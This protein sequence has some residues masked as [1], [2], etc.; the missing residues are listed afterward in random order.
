MTIQIIC[1]LSG[2]I[3]DQYNA[4][5][6]ARSIA[7]LYPSETI[8]V[9]DVKASEVDKADAL[10]KAFSDDD[11][12][13]VVGAGDDG[14]DAALALKADFK[15]RVYVSWSGHQLPEGREISSIDR[16]N[17]PKGVASH[18]SKV[19]LGDRLTETTG[20]PHNLTKADLEAE[21]LKWADRIPTTDKKK[22]VVVLGGDAP[23]ADNATQKFY[24]VK[25]AEELADYVADLARSGDYYI[26]ATSGPRVGKFNHT[27][28]EEDKTVHRGDTPVSEPTDPVSEAFVNRLKSK[29][30][31]AGR[32][33][34]FADFRYGSP[35]ISAYR[36]LLGLL[37]ESDVLMLP[38]ESV[39]MFSE[40]LGVANNRIGY[41][42]GSMNDGHYKTFGQF[43]KESPI[44]VLSLPTATGKRELAASPLS[45]EV[46]VSEPAAMII[47]KAIQ[48][49]LA[50]AKTPGLQR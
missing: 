31:E 24:T 22:L 39:S 50:V 45:G 29:G 42:T 33:F 32:D 13:I 6:V 8:F 27:T 4:Q 1:L 43:S 41:I 9:T 49:D 21:R 16:V 5:G 15:D 25:E 14:L 17:L 12:V 3:G 35:S 20:V 18:A 37:G 34:Y 40:T 38:G 23:L 19:V 7:S 10:I 46:G 30:F 48:T 26:Y 44:A 36:A 11:K 47:A 2:L 28:R